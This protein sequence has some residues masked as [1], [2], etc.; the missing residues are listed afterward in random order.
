MTVVE[1]GEGLVER[2]TDVHLEV[3]VDRESDDRRVVTLVPHGG[4]WAARLTRLELF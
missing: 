3:R 1:W 2:L 4:D